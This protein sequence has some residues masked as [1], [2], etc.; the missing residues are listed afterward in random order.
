LQV[1]LNQQK[2]NL[3]LMRWKKNWR[4]KVKNDSNKKLDR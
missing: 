2:L 3:P 1:L 4:S